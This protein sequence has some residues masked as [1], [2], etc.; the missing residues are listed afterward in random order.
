[1]GRGSNI[2]RPGYHNRYSDWLRAGRQRGRSS[3]PGRVKN[4]LFSPS[5][6][7]VLEPTQPIIWVPWAISLGVKRPVRE[8][9]PS[10]SSS[11]EVKNDG[12]IP[13]LPHTYS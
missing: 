10:P 7:L 4:F 8:G 2:F 6:R 9:D 13:S 1:M 5:S 11:A 3:S 12:A